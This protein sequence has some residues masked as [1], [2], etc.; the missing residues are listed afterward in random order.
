MQLATHLPLAASIGIKNHNQQIQAKKQSSKTTVSDIP[1]QVNL[2]SN[3][4]NNAPQ[5]SLAN[6]LAAYGDCV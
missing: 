6:L 2:A 3:D 5:I 4:T 1:E